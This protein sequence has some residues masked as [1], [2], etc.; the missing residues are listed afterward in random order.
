MAEGPLHRRR[1]EQ[2]GAADGLGALGGRRDGHR[3]T[4][5]EFKVVASDQVITL[6]GAGDE[7]DGRRIARDLAA[8]VGAGPVTFHDLRYAT[9][10]EAATVQVVEVEEQVGRNLEPRGQEAVVRV[11][12]EEL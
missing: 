12:L 3:P 6:T 10:G 1:A 2:P 8:L 11:V 4:P 9:T 5:L 7:R